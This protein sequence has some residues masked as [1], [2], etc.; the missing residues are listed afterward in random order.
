MNSK[1]LIETRN[2]KNIWRK[3]TG[4]YLLNTYRFCNH[5]INEFILLL[6]NSVYQCEYIN[7][8][9]KFNETTLPEEKYFYSHLNMKD[10]TE[11]DY[12]HVKYGECEK[13]HRLWTGYVKPKYGEKSYV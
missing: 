5:D 3:L 13:T 4:N 10:I 8:W 2:A 1:V 7:D 6:Q 11:A 9:E 12:T